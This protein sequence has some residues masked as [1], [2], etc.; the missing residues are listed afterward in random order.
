MSSHA[1]VGRPLRNKWKGR[2]TR[3]TEVSGFLTGA[4]RF[5]DDAAVGRALHNNRFVCKLK[6]RT[7]FDQ[8]SAENRA[9]T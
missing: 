9:L 6:P 1:A 8:A 2:E 3:C 7:V 4:A 5:V